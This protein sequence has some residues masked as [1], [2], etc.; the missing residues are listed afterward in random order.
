MAVM[1]SDLMGVEAEVEVGSWT[2]LLDLDTGVES[3]FT[4]VPPSESNPSLGR[5]SADS[6]VGRALLGHHLGETID[7]MTPRGR[8][9]LRLVRV[10]RSL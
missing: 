3:A 5:L 4:L 10:V 8:R 2:E 6:P 7:V 1:N 9:H